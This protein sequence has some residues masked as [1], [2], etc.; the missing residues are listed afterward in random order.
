MPSTLDK[1][2]QLAEKFAHEADEKLLSRLPCHEG[3]RPV[4]SHIPLFIPL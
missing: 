2:E 1:V 4:G 3:H